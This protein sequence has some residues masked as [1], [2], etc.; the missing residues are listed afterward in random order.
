MFFR[1]DWLDLLAVQGLLCTKQL[2]VGAVTVRV[3]RMLLPSQALQERAKNTNEG[4]VWCLP[5]ASQVLYTELRRPLWIHVLQVM[6]CR[7]GDVTELQAAVLSTW[8]LSLPY[9][10]NCTLSQ[11][12][13]ILD[14]SQ[15]SQTWEP[16]QALVGS[17][18]PQSKARASVSKHPTWT[19]A[20]GSAQKDPQGT[21]LMAV[22]L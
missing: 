14:A 10:G 20:W 15:A 13:S 12:F 5:Q 22:V 4:T 3:I 6:A 16:A 18:L 9:L 7:S 11:S 21:Q 17:P 19:S 8:I 2:G 1:I